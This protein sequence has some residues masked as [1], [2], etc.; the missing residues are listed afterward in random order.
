M[1]ATAKR[2]RRCRRCGAEV[3]ALVEVA[4]TARRAR[5][6]LDGMRLALPDDLTRSVRLVASALACYSQTC[7]THGPRDAA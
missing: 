5:L 2:P 6:A 3:P 4:E 7:S 1:T